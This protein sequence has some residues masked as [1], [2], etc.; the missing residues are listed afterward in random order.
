[1]V[2]ICISIGMGIECKDLLIHS[3]VYAESKRLNNIIE[4]NWNISWKG[5]IIDPENH[6]DLKHPMSYS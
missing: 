5:S 3:V 1:M 6:L 4:R 2:A